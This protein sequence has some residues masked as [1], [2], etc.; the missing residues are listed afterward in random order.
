MY[1]ISVFQIRPEPDFAGFMNSNQAEA[2][3]GFEK[4]YLTVMS[5]T[6]HKQETLSCYAYNS[7][8]PE[9]LGLTRVVSCA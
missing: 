3:A 9:I 6:K 5:T 8:R 1:R 4:I 7:V 2:G